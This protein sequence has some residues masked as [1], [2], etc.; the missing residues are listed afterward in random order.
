MMQIL[1]AKKNNSDALHIAIDTLQIELGVSGGV[2]FYMKTLVRA[3][4]QEAVNDARVT[5]LCM[6]DQLPKLHAIF[7]DQVDYY[8]FG[9]QPVVSFLA[10]IKK[11][12]FRR[13]VSTDFASTNLTFSR[14]RESLGVDILHSPVQIYSKMDFT[15]PG[16]LNLH[17]LQHLYY[18]ENFTDGDLEARN[19]F[20]RQSS[21]ISSA[22][23]ASS[24][25]VRQDIIHHLEVPASKVFTIPAAFNPNVEKGLLT[26]SQEQAKHNYNLPENFGF[27]PA[28]F[29]R[30][31]NH[32]RLIEALA[33]V[34]SRAPQHDF[35]LVFTG[36]RGHNGWPLVKRALDKF[37]MHDH[38]VLLDFI[39]T[40]HMGAIYRLATFCIVPSLFEASSYPVIEAQMLG[41]PAMCSRV[42]SLPELMAGGSGLLFDPLSPEDMADK[43]LFWLNN[44]ADRIAHAERGRERALKKHNLASYASSMVNV[45]KKIFNQHYYTRKR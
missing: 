16:V 8:A 44:P 35:K 21:A 25:F 1:E 41:C 6:P 42:T 40:E 15:V 5:L 14:L 31:K 20:Y 11:K 33:I 24:E 27:Y 43:M 7:D 10:F 29:W 39:S 22:I 26:F 37:R 32:V 12:L 2:E 18:P 28:Q 13:A 38:V 23:V 17:D 30:H 45:Y 4:I 3:L 34:R 36:Y 9:S 19:R